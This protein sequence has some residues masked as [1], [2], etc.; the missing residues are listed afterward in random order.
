MDPF[1]S[2]EVCAASP[3][4]VSVIQLVCIGDQIRGLGARSRGP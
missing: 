2:G 4:F 1:G 3:C